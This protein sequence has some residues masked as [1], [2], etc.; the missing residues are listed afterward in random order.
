MI[1]RCYNTHIESGSILVGGKYLSYRD[2]LQH[3]PFV[4]IQFYY[5]PRDCSYNL[6]LKK[7]RRFCLDFAD[8][9]LHEVIH[10]RQY[11]RRK[12]KPKPD[13]ISESTVN[14]RRK[15]QQYLGNEDEIQAYA[16]NI[17]CDL[18]DKFKSDYANIISYLNKTQGERKCKK[19]TVWQRYLH[20]FEYDHKHDVIK[21]LKKEVIRYLSRAARG[22]PYVSK[23]DR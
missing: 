4:L 21:R 9:V 10:I 12:F 6:D 1:R 20:A 16:F 5:N 13:Y 15:E 7:Y 14:W 18:N 8:T 22:R 2:A 23:M 17:A 3:V 11:R 19:F